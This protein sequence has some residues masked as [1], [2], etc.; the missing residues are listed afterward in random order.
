MLSW[1][2]ALLAQGQ[3]GNLTIKY[4]TNGKNKGH[5]LRA[6]ESLVSSKVQRNETIP[7]QQGTHGQ[8]EVP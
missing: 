3:D 4:N 5:I 6:F 2:G 1:V 8:L 7:F